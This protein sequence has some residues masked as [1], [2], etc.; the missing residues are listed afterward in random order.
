MRK[1]IGGATARRRGPIGMANRDHYNDM[2]YAETSQKIEVRRKAFI[3][4]WRIKH[5][6]VAVTHW[7]KRKLK[8]DE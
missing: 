8:R 1:L 7:G 6:A 5:R 4:K 2:I 3:R